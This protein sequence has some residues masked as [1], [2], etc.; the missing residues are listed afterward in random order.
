MLVAVRADE[1]VIPLGFFQIGGAGRI[2][3]EQFLELR[4]GL[5]ESQFLVLVNVKIYK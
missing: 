1:P 2:I 3:R 5:G 4:Q